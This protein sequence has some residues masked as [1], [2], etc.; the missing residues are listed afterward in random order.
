MGREKKGERDNICTLAGKVGCSVTSRGGQKYAC[1][2]GPVTA[3]MEDDGREG[4]WGG[5]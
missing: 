3:A 1:T 4:S 5:E 2:G